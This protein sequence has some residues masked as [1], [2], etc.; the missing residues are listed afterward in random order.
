MAYFSELCDQVVT[1]I[2]KQKSTPWIFLSGDLGAGKTTFTAELLSRLGFDP[3]EVQSPTFLKVISYKNSRGDLA[4]HMDAYRID[5]SSEFLRIGLEDYVSDA[6][7][8][9]VG[10]VEWPQKFVEFLDTYPAFKENLDVKNVLQIEISSDHKV[11]SFR[12]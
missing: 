5:E 11:L 12:E 4:L 2:D 8:I 1:W 3:K 7:N 9:R 6:E 10:I